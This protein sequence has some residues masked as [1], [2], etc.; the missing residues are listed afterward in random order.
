M[1]KLPSSFGINVITAYHL[2][3]A[4]AWITIQ[5]LSLSKYDTFASW[6]MP[7]L[8]C[9]DEH[10]GAV[11]VNDYPLGTPIVAAAFADFISLLPFTIA[12]TVGLMNRELYGLVF[13]WLVFGIHIYRT[14]F[15]F[16]QAATAGDVVWD[17]ATAGELATAGVVPITER[18]ILYASLVF[19][20]WGTW[21]QA[22]YLASSKGVGDYGHG[23]QHRANGVT[24]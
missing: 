15:V 2:L 9:F 18:S 20:V 4:L 14:L 5:S 23:Q 10:A 16:W 24:A 8:E 19:A 12:A 13:S 11:A 7:H 17:A 1:E 3:S 22:G 6:S 21:F